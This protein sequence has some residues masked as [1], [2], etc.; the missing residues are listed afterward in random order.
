MYGC[1]P[2]SF[3]SRDDLLGLSFFFDLFHLFD[4]RVF[5]SSLP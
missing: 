1:M 5:P 2:G 4:F 3:L